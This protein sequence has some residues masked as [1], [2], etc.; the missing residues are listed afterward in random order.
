M[1]IK[2][3]ILEFVEGSNKISFDELALDIYSYQAEHNSIYRKFLQL[4]GRLDME[5][6]CVNEIPCLPIALYKQ[7]EV[8]TGQWSSMHL[9]K[10]SGTSDMLERSIHHIKDLEFYNQLTHSIFKQF[11]RDDNYEILGLLPS[12]MEA[13][14][15]SLVAMVTHLMSIYNNDKQAF[16]MHDFERMYRDIDRL[17]TQTNKT[18]LI[19]GVTFALLD[20]AE[21]FKIDS[22]RLKLIFTGG[23]KGRRKELS[24]EEV[25]QHLQ[26]AFPSGTIDSEYGMTEM[27]SQAYTVEGY[28]G[29]Y[30]PGKSLRV[31]PREINDPFKNARY[32]KTSQL[33]FVDLGNVDTLSF[34][35]TDDLCTCYDDGSFDLHGRLRESDLRGCNMLYQS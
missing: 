11:Y 27:F 12:Y 20:F 13:G 4:S 18:I 22:N 31:I 25:K 29:T 28:R 6:Q 24:N 9:F 14:N 16:Y 34:V 3:K 21:E 23:M 33:A 32:G 19:F 7:Y 15:S 10:S 17:L 1:N 26:T 2:S 5:P 30:Y 35:M 8:K